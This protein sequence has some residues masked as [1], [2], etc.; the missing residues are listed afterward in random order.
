[1]LSK[2][3]VLL[4][5]DMSYGSNQTRKRILKKAETEFLECGFLGANLRSIASKA[6]V[7]TGAL[8]NHFKNKEV[9]FDSLVKEVSEEF[10]KTFKSKHLASTELDML[11]EQSEEGTD[12]MLNY[13]YDNFNVFKLIYCC[14]DGS[15]YVGYVDKLIEVEESTYRKTITCNS[16][17]NDLF[18]IHVVS[19][20]SIH[21]L[22]EVVEHDL[23]RSDAI[24]YMEKIKRYHFAAWNELR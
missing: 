12:W 21:N 6:K 15:S 5:R 1:M 9:L 19:S 16:S 23:S 11:E 20:M 2:I 4:E 18:F 14:S 24:E 7:T 10:Y 3:V 17:K 8:Y 13:V 22:F